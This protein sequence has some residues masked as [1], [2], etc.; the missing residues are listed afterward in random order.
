MADCSTTVAQ[1]RSLYRAGQ[2]DQASV[3]LN[4]C[5]AE[6]PQDFEAHLLLAVVNVEQRR[7]EDAH[8]AARAAVSLRATDASAWY[9]L[10]R[11]C[12]ESGDVLA[13]LAC[14]RRAQAIDPR[15]PAILTSL[16]T[17]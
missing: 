6:Y 11:A 4:G 9:A 1:A 17:V 10:G 13:A 8:A 15:N 3:L 12:K 16:G 5:L 7:W 14:Y 2:H